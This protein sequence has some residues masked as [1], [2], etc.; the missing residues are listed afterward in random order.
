[1]L[2][3]ICAVAALLATAC[4]SAETEP[5]SV[6][7]ATPDVDPDAIQVM[8]LGTYHF[9]GSTDLIN[10]ATADLFTERRQKELADLADA[11]AA[12][13][14]TVV[15][16]E[17]ETPPPDYIDPYFSD[18]DDDMLR[19][20][21]NERVQVAYRLARRAGVTRVHGIDEAPSEGEPDY[22]PFPKLAAHAK[23]TGQKDDLDALMARV[24][25]LV[26]QFSNETADD[27]IAE[28]LYKINTGFMSA[29][30]VYYAFSEF[31]R[32]EDQPG[33][34][35]QAYWFMRNAKIFSKLMQV[36]EPGD[37]V[38]VVYGAGHK[39]WLDHMADHMDGYMRVDP[40]P[41]LL[42]AFETE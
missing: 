26:G 36:V 42:K 28:K 10:V 31:D 27:H 14:P 2:K 5:T 20:N 21:Q 40:D 16:T 33:A 25:S 39:F 11:L 6:A 22:F 17:R 4:V 38:V 29:P 1:M 9:A 30:D 13:G 19:T 18:F 15:V 24:Q 3:S 34:E 23:A 7:N 32:G 12:F 37:R 41:Y 8:V 35:L